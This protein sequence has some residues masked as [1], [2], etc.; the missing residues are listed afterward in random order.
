MLF[1]IINPYILFLISIMFI[2]SLCT[3]L[4]RVKCNLEDSFRWR[5]F[6][7]MVIVT[8]CDMECWVPFWT[9]GVLVRC[10]DIYGGTPWAPASF[11]VLEK[12][13]RLLVWSC[14]ILSTFVQEICVLVLPCRNKLLKLFF[15]HCFFGGHEFVASPQCYPFFSP[16]LENS[17]EP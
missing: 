8:R 11:Y 2:T 16:P 10:R 1:Y 6:L 17:V 9:L 5:N 13:S 3:S 7:W 15:F 4:L 14:W 12:W